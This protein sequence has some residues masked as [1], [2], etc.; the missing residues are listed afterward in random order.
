MTKHLIVFDLFDV[1]EVTEV[2]WYSSFTE[3]L[4]VVF[5][6]LCVCVCLMIRDS[7]ASKHLL[8]GIIFCGSSE[9]LHRMYQL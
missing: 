8:D 3:L 5:G 1:C 9:V 7:C 4:V 6:L 2:N